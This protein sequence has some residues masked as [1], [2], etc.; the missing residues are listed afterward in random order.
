MYLK[1]P[2][3]NFY[4]LFKCLKKQHINLTSLKKYVL[5]MAVFKKNYINCY[6]NGRFLLWG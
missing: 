4:N 1:K 5:Y 3:D 6:I 2:P